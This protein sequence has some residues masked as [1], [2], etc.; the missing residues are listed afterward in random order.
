[1]V[2]TLVGLDGLDATADIDITCLSV[3]DSDGEAG[4]L[5]LMLLAVKDIVGGTEEGGVC[6][7][8]L[9]VKLKSRYG[10]RRDLA[11]FHYLGNYLGLL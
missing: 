1:M 4:A 8:G 2:Y 5:V 10:P 11:P 9:V 7:P 6:G 3:G